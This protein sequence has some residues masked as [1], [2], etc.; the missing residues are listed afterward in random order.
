MRLRQ[1]IPA[2]LSALSR[3]GTWRN[4]AQHAAKLVQ[5]LPAVHF[6]QGVVR[7]LPQRI[8]SLQQHFPF[9]RESDVPSPSIRPGDINDDKS[10]PFKQ[11]KIPSHRGSIHH[12][13]I[14]KI[15]N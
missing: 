13:G 5:E 2:E 15:V 10:I 4:L 1:Q 8:G 11:T 9:A 7:V 12:H 3:L 6:L 14:R